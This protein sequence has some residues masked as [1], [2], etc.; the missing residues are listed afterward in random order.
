MSI[1]K[2]RGSGFVG[3]TPLITGELADT[4]PS[5][6]ACLVPGFGVLWRWEDGAITGDVYASFLRYAIDIIRRCVVSGQTQIIVVQDNCRIHETAEVK[7]AV[8]ESQVSVMPTVPYC[9]RTT[10]H[11]IITSEL[12]AMLKRNLYL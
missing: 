10:E 4:R 2:V 6:L 1:K 5:I 12:A 9:V 11:Q 8:S 3:I 7:L